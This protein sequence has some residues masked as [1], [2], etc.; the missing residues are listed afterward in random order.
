MN[1]LVIPILDKMRAT[2][3]AVGAIVEVH[4]LDTPEAETQAAGLL[5]AVKTIHAAGE[6]ERKARKAPHL[7]AGREV[8]SIF[9]E[10]RKALER[11]ERMIKKRLAEAAEG[12]ERERESA[13]ALARTAAAAHDH[14]AASAALES[15]D[16][17]M[18][19]A[20]TPEGISTR[21]TYE[22]ESVQIEDVP[23]AFLSVNLEMVRAEIKTAA[24]E[25]RPP[26]VD[27]IDFRK[28]AGIVARRL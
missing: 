3:K 25:G 12:R 27:G 21:W 9:S 19:L 14:E 1:E 6:K 15:I 13:L 17:S 23:R 18:D 20:P 2:A 16:M 8:D 26:S 7:A 5:R 11:V 10:P 22:I 28:V 4:P 24:S